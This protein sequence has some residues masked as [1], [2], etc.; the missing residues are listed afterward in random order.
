MGGDLSL[1]LQGLKTT[2]AVLVGSDHSSVDRSVSFTLGTGMGPT[3]DVMFKYGDGPNTNTWGLEQIEIEYELNG[4]LH[5]LFALFHQKKTVIYAANGRPYSCMGQRIE[6]DLFELESQGPVDIT[7]SSSSS[8]SGSATPTPPPTPSEPKLGSVSVGTLTMTGSYFYG[9]IGG[10]KGSHP[11]CMA[12]TQEGTSVPCDLGSGT[13][14]GHIIQCP[15][16]QEDEEVAGRRKV[17]QGSALASFFILFMFF[18]SLYCCI[19]I[20]YKKFVVK[21]EGVAQLPNA[22][23]WVGVGRGCGNLGN[24]IRS[25]CS[26]TPPGYSAASLEP[27][28]YDF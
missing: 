4:E 16:K 23:F 25:K 18:F 20:G 14:P 1:A 21:A 15:V 28:E 26:R 27:P 10:Q 22:S 7:S 3:V 13:T 12:D 8:S 17:Q 5:H 19:G 6:L 11:V 24:T 2:D 9:V